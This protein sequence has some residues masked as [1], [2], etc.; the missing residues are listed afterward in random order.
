MRYSQEELNELAS[1]IS[2]VDYI[3]QTE[4]LHRK[5]DKYFIK[6]PFHKGDDTPSLCIYPDT[7]SW[8]CFGCGEGGNI[9]NWIMTKD[10]VGFGKAVERVASILGIEFKPHIE[11]PT[12]QFFKTLHKQNT[13]MKK[14]H[15]ER[16][17]LDWNTDYIEK[18]SD[19]LPQEWLDEDMTPEA[20]RHYNIR[21]DK[22]ANRIVYPV[23]DSDNRF[24]G[25]KGRTRIK[26][27]KLLGLQKYINYDKIGTIDYF[28][29]Y[30]Q[31]ISEIKYRKSVIIFEGIKS[32]IKAWGWNIK[33][34][35]AS[36]TAALSDGQLQLLIKS[37]L[38][39]VI[40]GW[41]TDQE[42]KKIVGDPK[43]QMLKR[44]T[45]VGVITDKNHLL[46][47]KMAPTDRGESV[48]RKLLGERIRI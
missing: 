38:A 15:V 8:H 5:G 11:T 39:E 43:I 40:F 28:Q 20:L 13:G 24:I 18:Y 26:E 25:V 10:N 4:E 12:V 31:A 3:E 30:Q 34:T 21:I 37:G 46:G 48:F 9:Y 16:H 29:G 35:V 2:L 36:E 32:C 27:Y 1:K 6:C 47:E 22:S 42:L 44:F 7:N 41:D 17:V 14:Q 19:E 23:L 45:K 33:N